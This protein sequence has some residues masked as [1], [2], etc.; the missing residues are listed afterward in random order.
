MSETLNFL[1]A[2]VSETDDGLVINGK[3]ELAGGTINAS[4]DHRIA[5]MAAIAALRCKNEV[6]IENA[7]AVNK[8]Y[9]AFFEDY[10]RLSGK[11]EY[12]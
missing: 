9:P 10:N 8:S 1:G 7:E 5:M 3:P 6:I 4:G 2:D 12:K 11:V